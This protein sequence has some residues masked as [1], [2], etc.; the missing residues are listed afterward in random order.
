MRYLSTFL[1]CVVL[2]LTSHAVHA[3]TSKQQLPHPAGCPKSLFCGCGAAVTIY[4]SPKR[5]LWPASAW[6][7]FP[8]T[9]PAPGMVAV[10]SHHVFVI[11]Q[12][13]GPSTVLAIDHN[14]GGGRSW[15]VV[16]SL[17]GYSVRNPHG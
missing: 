17:A 3:K 12:V 8:K 6:F 2:F 9:S 1:M 7:K 15:L 5:E 16:R 14:S 10:R 4:G 11:K 13:L